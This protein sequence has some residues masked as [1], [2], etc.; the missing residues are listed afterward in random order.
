MNRR[1][2]LVTVAVSALRPMSGSASDGPFS[3]EEKERF[4]L[5]GKVVKTRE[6]TTGITGSRRVTLQQG[7]FSHEA[8]LQT[9]DFSKAEYKT[10]FGTEMNFRDSYKFNIAAHRLDRLINLNMVPVSVERKVQGKTGSMTWWV[11]DVQMMERE[12]STRR[13]SPRA[14]SSGWTRC[15]TFGCSTNWSTTP[16]PTWGTC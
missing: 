15:T 3:D 8:H 10:P 11:D 6:T 14:H 7:D 1:I 5:Q 4:L 9:I 16:T 13:S 2:F 12:R